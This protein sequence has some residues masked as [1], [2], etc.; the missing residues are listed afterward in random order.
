MILGKGGRERQQR[1]EKIWKRNR[2][3]FLPLSPMHPPSPLRFAQ[4]HQTLSRKKGRK[5][6]NARERERERER[7][8]VF[9]S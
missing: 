4:K 8:R 5:K 9:F 6:R 7:E 2:Q 1:E 3:K